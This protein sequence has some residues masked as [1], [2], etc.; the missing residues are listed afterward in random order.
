MA[1]R[2]RQDVT[3]VLT[4]EGGDEV[5]GG[6]RRYVAEQMHPPYAIV[7]R[8]LRALAARAD[9]ERIPPL[10]R[11]GRTL[12]ALAIDDR[13]RRYASRAETFDTGERRAVLRRDV[14]RPVT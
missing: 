9:I 12:R 4:G 5:F 7:P 14:D 3:G 10:R 2:A 11:V 13:A 6:Y 8:P 1:K